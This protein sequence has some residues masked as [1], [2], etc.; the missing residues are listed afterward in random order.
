MNDIIRTDFANEV[1]VKKLYKF[2]GIKQKC[3]KS[4]VESDSK[5]EKVALKHKDIPSDDLRCPTCRG[6]V[7][8]HIGNL[9]EDQWHFEHKYAVDALKC[10]RS[11]MNKNQQ[12]RN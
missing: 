12:P 2:N 8:I 11:P 7:T 4:E 6:E 10:T 5:H 9:P 1:D 3:W